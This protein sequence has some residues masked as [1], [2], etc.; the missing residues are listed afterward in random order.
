MATGHIRPRPSKDG[1]TRFQII[2][3]SDIDVE[4]GKRNR[5]YRTI[6]GSKKDA[7]KVMREMIG[8]I[9]NQTFIKDSKVTLKAFLLEWLNV[10]IR[11]HKSPTTVQGYVFQVEKYLVPALGN[12]KLQDLKAI[13]IQ[14]FYN[15]LQ[16]NSTL[17]GKPLSP[18]YIK[19]IHMNL[20]GALEKAVE[21]GV[22]PK[23]PAKLVQ[24]P[25]VKKYRAEVYS[26]DEIQKLFQLVKGTDLELAVHILLSLGLRR[27]ELL[28][29]R[30]KAIDFDKGIISVQENLVKAQGQLYYKDP[31]S[32][33]GK[34]DIGVSDSLLAMLK[35]AKA[36]YLENKVRYGKDFE[37]N[38]LVVCQPN[39]KP[40]TPDGFSQK[41]RRF[42]RQHGFKQIRLH[43][44]RHSNGTAMLKMGISAKVAQKRLGH[45]DYG[46]TMNI[47]SHVLD[48]IEKDAVDKM[49]Q[50]FYSGV[51]SS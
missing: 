25:K 33:S 22:I 31:K 23:N 15:Q 13:D 51:S 36:K 45:A 30:W 48:D 10:Y 39:G 20:Q 2:V 5:L 37:D 18:K 24:L 38:D 9:D 21:Q 14:K 3:E 1:R 29:L 42:L 32:E 46:T 12:K 35:A 8:Q 16:E 6:D 17:T 50:G 11:P 41:I 49:E 43:D 7:E 19:N 34:R 4:T 27:G 44:F 40:Y 28:A 47:Y 26:M